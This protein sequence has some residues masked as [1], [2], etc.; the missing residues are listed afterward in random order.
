[1]PPVSPGTASDPDRHGR[2]AVWIAALITIIGAGM[3]YADKAAE[4]R[5]AFIRWRPQVLEMLAGANIYDEYYFPNPPIMPL[6]LYPLMTL[7]PVEGALVWFALK[8]ALT[9]PLGLDLLADGPARRPA[10]AVLGPGDDRPAQ[11]PA[12][13]GRPAPRQQ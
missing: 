4:D 13:P 3:I 11:P 9:A 7:P 6:T 1:M 8:A 10:G 2:R 5:S 12:D